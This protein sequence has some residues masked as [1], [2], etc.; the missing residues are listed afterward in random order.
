MFLGRGGGGVSCSQGGGLSCSQGGGGYHVPREGGRLSC[1][2]GGGRLSCSQ[3]GGRLSC[4]QGG[5]GVLSCSQG[6]GSYHVPRGRGGGY[7]VSREEEAIMFPRGS[8]IRGYD[9]QCQGL[10]L[11]LKGR[12]ALVH[13]RTGRLPQLV[14]V[15]QL[16]FCVTRSKYSPPPHWIR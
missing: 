11:L 3:G 4:S 6:G 7:H 1:S 8:Q 2:Q 5:G 10:L 9:G 14:A 16:Q 12:T 15:G 13:G